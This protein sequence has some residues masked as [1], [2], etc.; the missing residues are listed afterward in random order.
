MAPS[1]LNLNGVMWPEFWS[2]WGFGIGLARAGGCPPR[3]E[4]GHSYLWKIWSRQ[5]R[6]V[7]PGAADGDAGWGQRDGV[8]PVSGCERYQRWIVHWEGA[9]RWGR[10]W[11][12]P[13]SSLIC[14]SEGHKVCQGS[15]PVCPVNQQALWAEPQWL[16]EAPPTKCLKRPPLIFTHKKSWMT[17]AELN[18]Q[19]RE[20]KRKT[21]QRWQI[22]N[23]EKAGFYLNTPNPELNLNS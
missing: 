8:E 19:E 14:Y 2:I 18:S 10:C 21:T 11:K 15:G 13:V 1:I 9:R 23:P 20:A 16:T 12:V 17:S 5:R 3:R 22:I 4:N 6:K 7:G